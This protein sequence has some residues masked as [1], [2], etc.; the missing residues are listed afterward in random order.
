MWQFFPHIS[1]C[2]T[3]EEKQITKCEIKG[4]FSVYLEKEQRAC[5]P[6]P[7]SAGYPLVLL[8]VTFY[9]YYERAAIGFILLLLFFL[10]L[11]GNFETNFHNLWTTTKV[12][13]P[14]HML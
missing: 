13:Q 11:F 5:R 8:R 3:A 2:F 4:K 1:V 14:W 6:R 7:L 12:T 9:P 10:S